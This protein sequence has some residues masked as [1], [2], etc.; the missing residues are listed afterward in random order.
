MKIVWHR[1]AYA[2]NA[3]VY[4]RTRDSVYDFVRQ[5]FWNGAGRKQLTVKHGG[6]WSTYRPLEMFRR[7]VR[8]WSIIR[9]AVAL[10]GYVGYKMFGRLRVVA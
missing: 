5:A 2:P 9:L 10:L 8:F 3:I 6:L 4:H 7:Q 1:I